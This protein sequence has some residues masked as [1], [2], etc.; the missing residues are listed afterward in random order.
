MVEDIERFNPELRMQSV[1]D[2]E[3]RED[4]SPKA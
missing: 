2:V 3:S 4:T 1:G